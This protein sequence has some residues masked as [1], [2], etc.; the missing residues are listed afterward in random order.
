MSPFSALLPAI[1]NLSGYSVHAG[2]VAVSASG[3]A[4]EVVLET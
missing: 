4:R 3:V 2:C 1:F